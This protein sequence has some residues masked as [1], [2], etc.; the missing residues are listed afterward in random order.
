MEHLPDRQ[1]KFKIFQD[2]LTTNEGELCVS[3]GEI[4]QVWRPFVVISSY[5]SPSQSLHIIDVRP[6]KVTLSSSS[7]NFQANSFFVIF[8]LWLKVKDYVDEKEQL[9]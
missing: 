3:V 8:H 2:F 4:L 1:F 9:C 5:T 7:S 6:F